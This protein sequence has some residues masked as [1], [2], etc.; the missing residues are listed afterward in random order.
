[1]RRILFVTTIC[2]LTAL[3]VRAMD[4]V[5]PESEPSLDIA[6]G[7]WKEAARTRDAL[8]I[9]KAE[10]GVLAAMRELDLQE[11]E[12]LAGAVILE[13]RRRIAASDPNADRIAEFAVRL[14]PS[15]PQ[16]HWTLARARFASAPLS[17]GAWLGPAIE[18]A[19]TPAETDRHGRPLLANGIFVLAVALAVAGMVASLVAVPRHLRRFAHDLRHLLP[20][21]PHPALAATVVL[22]A[23]ALAF[24]K[25]GGPL[26]WLA[27]TVLLF[28]P[29]LARQERWVLAVFFVVGGQLPLLLGWA[30]EN[31][32][33]GSSRAALLDAVDARG[34]FSRMEELREASTD[35]EAAAETLFALARYEKRKGRL[36]EARTLYDR[37]LALR[38]DWPA[39]LVNRANLHFVDGEF[40]EARTKYERAVRLKPD[41]PE[42]W[43]GLSRVHYRSVRIGEGQEARDRALELAPDLAERYNA[44]EEEPHRYLV[45]A[46]LSS[47][48][49]APLAQADDALSAAGA[50]LLWGVVPEA[51]A[52]IAGG[53]L[54]LAILLAPILVPGLRPSRGC[55]R[56][57]APICLRCDRGLAGGEVCSPCS[58]VFSRQ[59]GLDPSIRNRKEVEVARY[60]RRRHRLVR[61]ASLVTV[62]PLLLGRT[63]AGFVL[64]TIA[65]VSILGWIGGPHPPIFGDWPAGLRAVFSLPLVAAVAA[66]NWICARGGD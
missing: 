39:A 30:E 9:R 28:S 27:L 11:S 41:L 50:A 55:E 64:V 22:G 65:V 33:W 62:G 32:G 46:G 20:G 16:T 21:R 19:T 58:Q 8:A 15:L 49:L 57:G 24:V 14:A 7:A 1:M 48:D 25:T 3:P 6:W 45:D 47:R 52:P 54:A 10:E 31:T 18:A 17:V 44:S 2:L 12:P 43:F 56:C 66:S 42:A 23:L 61:L 35:A 53:V 37:V 40:E 4:A 51:A 34:D 60:Q 13:A 5:S 38:P 29:Y 26:L 63:A 59:R 36:E